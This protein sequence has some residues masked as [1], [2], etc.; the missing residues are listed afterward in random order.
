MFEKEHEKKLCNGVIEKLRELVTSEEL[1]EMADWS[2]EDLQDRLIF[3]LEDVLRVIKD[4]CNDIRV[5]RYLNKKG[6]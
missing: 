6:V 2:L 4:S 1:E 5:C 3:E